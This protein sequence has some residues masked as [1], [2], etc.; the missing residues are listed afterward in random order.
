VVDASLDEAIIEDLGEATVVL[1]WHVTDPQPRHNVV[2]VR[3]STRQ[4][5]DD[6]TDQLPVSS[7]AHALVGVDGGPSSALRLIGTFLA[8]LL[9]SRPRHAPPAKLLAACLDPRVAPQG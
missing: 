5:V 2:R 9:M 3:L 1:I 7:V 6:S 4:Q 8:V